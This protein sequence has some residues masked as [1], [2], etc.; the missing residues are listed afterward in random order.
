MNHDRFNSLFFFRSNNS[1]SS[2]HKKKLDSSK[3]CNK[4]AEKTLGPIKGRTAMLYPS[5]ALLCKKCG[6][7][8]RGYE[9]MK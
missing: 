1:V 3:Y 2:H 9:N 4:C 7:I 5:D 8:Q 6:N